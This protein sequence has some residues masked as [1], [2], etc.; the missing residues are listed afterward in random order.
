MPSNG[1]IMRLFQV[2]TKP[3]CADEL[4]RK[5]ATTSADVVRNEPGNEGY[6]FG[7]GVATDGDF[8]LFASFWEDLEAV[9]ARFGEDWDRSFL[10]PGYEDLI[11]SCSVRHVDMQG[12]WHVTLPDQ[13][14]RTVR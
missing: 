11:D 4:M 12:G 10:P 9:K 5:F 8:V 6:F 2:Q 14:E 1:P 7:R 3:G 13:D